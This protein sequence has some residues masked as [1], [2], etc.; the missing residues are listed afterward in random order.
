MSLF[1]AMQHRRGRV[2][3]VSRTN[4]CR[5][6]MAEAFARA[7]GDNVMLAFSAGVWPEEAVSDAARV[8]MAEGATPLFT[9]QGQSASPTSISPAST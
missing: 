9:D 1:E 3:F 4:A 7:V 8:V 2:L 5:G 6:Q